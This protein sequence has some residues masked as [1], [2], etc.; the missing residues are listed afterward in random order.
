VG[1]SGFCILCMSSL[2][3]MYFFLKLSKELKH[4]GHKKVVTESLVNLVPL[5]KL[6]LLLC[7]ILQKYIVLFI[8]NEDFLAI[9]EV[10]YLQLVADLI[11]TCS[12]IFGYFFVVH[13]KTRYFFFF[14]FISTVCYYG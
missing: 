3:C 7:F 8:Y 4:N 10:F 5:V 13:Q 9:T 1:L 12:L 11:K 2:C 14:E 6:G